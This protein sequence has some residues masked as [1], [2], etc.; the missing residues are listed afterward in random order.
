MQLLPA[1]NLAVEDRRR[2]ETA[3]R[4]PSCD[5]LQLGAAA[6]T[7]TAGMAGISGMGAGRG[8]LGR[9][10]GA[11]S[12]AEWR[13]AAVL[14]SVVLG[15]HV[16]GFA[17]LFWFVAPQH[18]SIG[19]GVFGVGVGITAYTLGM[20]HAFDADHIGAIDNTTRKLMSEG[21]RPLSVG[22]FFS[23]GHSSVVFLLAAGFALGVRGLSGAVSGRDSPLHQAAGV[24]GPAVSGAFLLL[25]G[26]LNLVVLVS[27][28]RIFLRMRHG[29]F[30]EG[31]L[32]RQLERRGAMTRVYGKAARAVRKPWH[33]YPLGLL[34]GLGFD[35]ATEIAL[36]ATAGSAAAG[37]LP[38]PAIL[39]LP[40]LFA[41]GMSLLD[42]ID[43][44]FMNFAYGWA[45]SRPLR[46]I[47]Y[48][49]TVTG[50][51]V[52]VALVIGSVELVAVLAEKLSL[53]GGVWD[54]VSGLDLNLVG[55]AI[56]ALFVVTWV[57]AYAVW[58][59][60]R[61]EERWNA[62]LPERAS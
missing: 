11:L 30:D 3:R 55:Y 45:F 40:I 54:S 35:T 53:T 12:P 16:A 60:G 39:C 41:A 23:L 49:I 46:K 50:L 61:V 42:T 7:V 24:I 18:L 1:V 44:A 32:E 29:A 9:V 10:A 17:L 57:L 4:R 48:N 20:R 43:G 52:A 8:R 5:R 33:M 58:R 15:L 38:L 37:G 13:R 25:I 6:G 27:M 21:Q 59:F 28:L 22:F 14:A 19:T 26:I 31:A 34:F 56:V 36:L 2:P 62:R 51:S 47:F